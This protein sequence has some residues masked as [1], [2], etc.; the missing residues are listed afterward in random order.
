MAYKYATGLGSRATTH[1]IKGTPSGSVTTSEAH[2][3]VFAVGDD[4]AK[5]AARTPVADQRLVY[6]AANLVDTFWVQSTSE[7]TPKAG[8]KVTIRD[9]KPTTDPYNL[10]IVEIGGTGGSRR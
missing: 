1:A 8:T 7:A 2:S 5:S 4:W 6:Q 10:V 9:S 3:W